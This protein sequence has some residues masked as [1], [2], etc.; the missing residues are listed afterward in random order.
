M[1]APPASVEAA[2]PQDLSIR[3]TFPAELSPARQWEAVVELRSRVERRFAREG[4]DLPFP[5]VVVA[6]LPAPAPI[7]AAPSE[8]PQE[9]P[10]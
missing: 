7:V 9:E 4:V 5:R 1:L 6:R 2:R 3:V 8:P 10:A